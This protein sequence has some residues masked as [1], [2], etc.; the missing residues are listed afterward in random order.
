MQKREGARETCAV[1]HIYLGIV[2]VFTN[3]CWRHPPSLLPDPLTN[4]TGSGIVKYCPL[5]GAH[6]S[7]KNAFQKPT[8][9]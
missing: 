9:I 1:L 5:R 7:E 4:L 3:T 2:A 8:V 6:V